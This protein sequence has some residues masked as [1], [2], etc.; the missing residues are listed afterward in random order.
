MALRMDRANLL[1]ATAFGA[2]LL[3][4]SC[5]CKIKEEQQAM[6]NQLRTS[7]K[8]LTADIKKAEGDKTKIL[9]EVTSRQGEV[10]RCTEKKA[11]VQDKMNRWPNVWPD[12]NP[13]Q[14]APAMPM[15]EPQTPK[16]R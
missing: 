9:A 10:R 3:L 7:D 6:I 13:N 15:T 14:P 1:L 4:T 5:T 16:K 8:Q 2:A 12:W 11:F